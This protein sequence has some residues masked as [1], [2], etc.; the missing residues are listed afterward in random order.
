MSN[1]LDKLVPPLSG[2]IV[3]LATER[4]LNVG[5]NNIKEIPTLRNKFRSQSADM[6]ISSSYP[7]GEIAMNISKDTTVHELTQIEGLSFQEQRVVGLNM[8]GGKT[9]SLEFA[10]KVYRLPH[11]VDAYRMYQEECQHVELPLAT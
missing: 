11:P 9:N 1:E 3:A 4:L 6:D 8:L 2:W 10:T 7:N 5:L